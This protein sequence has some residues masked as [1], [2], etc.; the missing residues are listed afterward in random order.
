MHIR[1]KADI[2]DWIVRAALAGVGEVA[3]L[4][5]VCERLAAAGIELMRASI[6]NDLLDPTFDGRGVRWVQGQGGIEE[7]FPRAAGEVV[8]ETWARSPFYAVTEGGRERLR[9]HLDSRYRRGEFPLLDRFADQGAT[10]YVAFA[11]RVDERVRLGEGQG[12]VSS[13]M[14]AA[15][16]GFSEADV[17][18]L[19][20]ILPTLAMAFMLWTINRTARTAITTYLGSDAAERV[21]A[22]NI[23]RGRAAPISAVVWFSDLVAFTRITDT[24]TPGGRAG[25]AERLCRSA[26]R[27]DRGQRRARAEVHRRRNPRDLPR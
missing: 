5:G 27:G 10:D 7:A 24:V 8:N 26:G 3:I 4:T 12:M 1:L 2:T 25:P 17:E 18:L 19:G 22:G 11:T 14:T 21:L 23:V 13:W 9:R 20:G 6:A 15:P 16:G